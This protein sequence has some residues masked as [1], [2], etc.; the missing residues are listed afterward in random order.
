MRTLNSST[1]LDLPLKL[2]RKRLEVLG[3]N[4]NEYSDGSSSD[5]HTLVLPGEEE[6]A[7]ICA[8]KE[9]LLA[10]G[11]NGKVFQTSLLGVASILFI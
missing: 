1:P 4:A 2:A 9:F 6:V 7:Q 11:I 5:M 8:G 3:G 10:R